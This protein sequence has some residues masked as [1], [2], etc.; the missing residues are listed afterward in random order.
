MVQPLKFRALEFEWDEYNLD[1]LAMR[2]ISFW[3]AEECFFNSPRVCRN[4]KYPHRKEET[5]RL[6]GRTKNGRS[7]TLIFF[8][9]EKT[10]VRSP[11]GSIALI[12]IITG[13]RN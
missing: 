11:F 1:K 8:V 3:E 12:R 9:K 13:W 5:F 10:S 4:K 2:S 6:E 7:L